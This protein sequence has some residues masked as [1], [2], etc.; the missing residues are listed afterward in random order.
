VLKNNRGFTL[1]ELSIV[2]VIIGLIIGGIVAG[3][4]LVRQS[5]ITSIMT[6]IQRYAQAVDS[7]NQKYGA[8]PGDFA[9]ATSYWS[10]SGNGNGDGQVTVG[11]SFRFWQHLAN[12]SLI[13]GSYSGVSGS[14]GLGIFDHVIGTN[15][16]KS[17]INNSGYGVTWVGVKSGVT[18]DTNYFDGSYKHAMI[19]GNYSTNNLP[20]TAAL[21]T[22]EM[23]GFDSK[24][25]DG[26]PSTG[27]I[28]TW[29]LTTGYTPSCATSVTAYNIASKGLKCSL[30]M[31]L[32][33]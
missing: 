29:K 20:V 32:D 6:D 26:S 5:Q 19:F 14:G 22:D 17:K 7:F 21:T 18:A 24:Y 12:A 10:T 30:V 15:A 28:L 11:E 4:S 27:K 13:E 8:L 9:T 16:P 33:F 25:D 1:I 2:L 3:Q 31:P 23:L